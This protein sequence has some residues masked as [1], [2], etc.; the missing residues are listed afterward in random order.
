MTAP[1]WADCTDSLTLTVTG[2]ESGTI[3]G[4]YGCTVS[5]YAVE[6]TLAGT[7]ASST[8]SGNATMT[9]STDPSTPG[10]YMGTPTWTGVFDADGGPSL[11]GTINSFSFTAALPAGGA[12][13]VTLSG[14][15]S[16]TKDTSP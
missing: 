9:V 3:S 4:S 10:E 15:F 1:T 16:V 2:E 13:T 7:L 5:D 12:A 8:A 14:S 6:V 11:D